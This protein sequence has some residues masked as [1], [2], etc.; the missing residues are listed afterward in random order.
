MP[1]IKERE[2][3]LCSRSNVHILR[4]YF[5]CYKVLFFF[6]VTIGSLCVDKNV[7]KKCPSAEHLTPVDR[8]TM[9]GLPWVGE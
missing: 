7:F 5:L 9:N 2:E 3:N 6:L 4:A 1:I 8:N